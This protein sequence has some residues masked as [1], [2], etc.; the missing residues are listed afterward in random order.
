M[1]KALHEGS[2]F[3][4]NHFLSVRGWE[5]KFISSAAQLT[6]VALWV[7]LP[8]LPTEFYDFEILKKV[9]N[10]IGQLLK[11]DTCTTTTTRGRY[12]RIYIEVPLKT[13][14]HI[15]THKQ[16]FLCEGL[17]L[18][19]TKCGRFG[20]AGWNCQ[21]SLT[22][23]LNS[24]PSIITSTPNTSSTTPI[25]DSEWKTI[26]FPKKNTRYGRNTQRRQ[27]AEVQNFPTDN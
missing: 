5:P 24:I 19:Y 4:L 1:C 20:H 2:W 12:A 11:V 13:H 8:E 18:L 22:P 14:I 3:I 9:G 17:N 25:N 15:G 27:S 16:V 7:R 10:K 23:P 21:F 6:Y 26:T